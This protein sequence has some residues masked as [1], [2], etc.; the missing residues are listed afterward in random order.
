MKSAP[1]RS[2]AWP[3]GRDFRLTPI[4]GNI[5]RG[6]NSRAGPIGELVLGLIHGQLNVH[7]CFAGSRLAPSI[8][9]PPYP[10]FVFPR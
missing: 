9:G 6:A 8:T 2:A 1:V 7:P 5:L 10:D 3:H 4:F